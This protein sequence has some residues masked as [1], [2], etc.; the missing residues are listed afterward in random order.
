MMDEIKRHKMHG[1]IFRV[2]ILGIIL[3]I[4][5]LI[6]DNIPYFLKI[7]YI[8]VLILGL[9]MLVVLDLQEAAGYC[10]V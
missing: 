1:F 3:C 4:N 5:F 7:F 10:G 6:I 9:I 2:F 8:D